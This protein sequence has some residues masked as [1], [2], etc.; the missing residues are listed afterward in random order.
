MKAGDERRARGIERGMDLPYI[1]EHS[2]AVTA[3]SD[4]VWAALLRVLK[5]HMGGSEAFARVLGCE[6]S[7]TSTTFTGREG[8]TVPGFRV[9][10][11]EQGK[12]LALRGKH[13]FSR[14]ALTFLLDGDR[15]RAQTHAEFPGVLGA[16]YRAAVIGTGA[17][18]LVT[19][20]L[21]AQIARA[22]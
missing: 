21:L 22:A 9:A 20:R 10:E 13:R 6:P 17:H 5:R 14:Y 8:D 4:E 18:K 12:R 19:R 15:L 3:S 7:A 1:D 16:M 2:V 11:A